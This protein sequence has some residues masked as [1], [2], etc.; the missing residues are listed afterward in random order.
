MT[1]SFATNNHTQA[2]EDHNAVYEKLSKGDISLSPYATWDVQLIQ[3]HREDEDALA[4]LRGFQNKSSI[5]V[6]LNGHGTYVT[7]NAITVENLELYYGAH[8]I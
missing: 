8:I 1:W 5:W 6:E 2:P 4:R 7:P 3:K